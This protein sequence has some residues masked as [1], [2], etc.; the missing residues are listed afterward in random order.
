MCVLKAQFEDPR[1]KGSR[2]SSGLIPSIPPPN[3]PA[4]PALPSFSE[5]TPGYVTPPQLDNLVWA[6]LYFLK[7][8]FFFVFGRNV[9]FYIFVLSYFVVKCY[10]M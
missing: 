8:L 10:F 6:L 5:L 9:N 2:H 7:P 4:H 1:F 3:P